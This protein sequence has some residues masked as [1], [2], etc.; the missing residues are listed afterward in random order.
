MELYTIDECAKLLKCSDKT[1]RRLIEKKKLLA[2]DIGAANRRVYRISA[3]ELDR[4][5]EKTATNK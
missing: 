1:V 2:H 5:L 3:E 4:F